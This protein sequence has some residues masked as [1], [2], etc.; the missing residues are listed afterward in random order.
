MAFAMP[1]AEVADAAVAKA[2]QKAAAKKAAPAPA[3]KA[4]PAPARKTAPAQEKPLPRGPEP[5]AA[6]AARGG[7]G[8]VKPPKPGK[9]GNWLLSG[10]RK[11][12]TAEYVACVAILGAGTLVAPQGSKDGTVR[13]MVKFT[14]LSAVFFLLAMVGSAGKGAARAATGLGALITAAY[15]FTSSDV[16]DVAAWTSA[17][18]DPKGDITKKQPKGSGP[19]G[20]TGAAS[21]AGSIPAGPSNGQTPSGIP[22]NPGTLTGPGFGFNGPGG[23]GGVLVD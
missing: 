15:L 10:D 19:V 12:L 5:K 13:A 7:G 23:G 8:G 16:H 11:L 1:A 2:G 3:K 22:S 21:G 20:L 4:A 17:F 18:F 14:A 6:P 9:V